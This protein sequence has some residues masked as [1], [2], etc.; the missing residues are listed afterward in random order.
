M[1]FNTSENSNLFKLKIKIPQDL[2]SGTSIDWV[3]ATQNVPLAYTFEFR[4]SRNGKF[5]FKCFATQLFVGW[6][7]GNDEIGKKKLEFQI[8]RYGFVLPANQIIPNALETMDG[9]KALLKEAKVR[10]YL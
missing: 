10:R 4:D 1:R 5:D 6:A 8:G 9:L 2:A 7:F 3:H